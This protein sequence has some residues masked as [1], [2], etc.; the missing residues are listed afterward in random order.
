VDS[1]D[2]GEWTHTVDSG[3]TVVT[4]SGDRQWLQW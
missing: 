3:Q 2:S 1:S 4:D